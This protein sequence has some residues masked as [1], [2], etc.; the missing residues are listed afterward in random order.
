MACAGDTW[1]KCPLYSGLTPNA[2]SRPKDG[3]L[4]AVLSVVLRSSVIF[5]VAAGAGCATG[6]LGFAVLTVFLLRLGSSTLWVGTA[7]GG[8]TF[9]LALGGELFFTRAPTSVLLL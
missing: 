2:L 6:P 3:G 5:T 8:A 1:L 4:V 9:L 7:P